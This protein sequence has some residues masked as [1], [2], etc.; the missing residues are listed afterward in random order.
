[1]TEREFSVGTIHRMKVLEVGSSHRTI[2]AAASGSLDNTTAEAA[3]NVGGKDAQWETL[4]LEKVLN[5]LVEES[6]HFKDL[7]SDLLR[8]KGALVTLLL[9]AR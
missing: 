8:D 2:S 9:S 4:H 6:P 5:Y 7:V 3:I 1:M